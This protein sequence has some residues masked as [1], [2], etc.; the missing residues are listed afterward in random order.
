M[1]R[2]ELLYVEGSLLQEP[3]KLPNRSRWII[4]T[5]SIWHPTGAEE[6]TGNLI[7]NV[8]A[9]RREWRYGDR[10]RFKVR[11]V[12]PRDSGNPGGFNYANYLAR[13]EI[14]ASGFLDN[15]QEVELVQR[16]SGAVRGSIED[17]RRDD[18][19]PYPGKLL[20]L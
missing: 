5:Q 2:A 11:P 7:V 17:L 6:I 1:N 8:R 4:R 19:P 12:V 14:Y 16:E 15:D 9:V 3:E 13:R 20:C 18:S 10:V